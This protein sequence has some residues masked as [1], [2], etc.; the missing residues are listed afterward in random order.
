MGQEPFYSMQHVEAA[1]RY[2]EKHRYEEVISL[3]KNA[4]VTLFSAGHVLGSSIYKFEIAG[5]TL[6]FT[7]D[8]GNAPA[9]LIGPPDYVGKTDYLIIESAYG[10]R[11]HEPANV[12]AKLL[13]EIVMETVNRGGVL[14][15]PSF[16]VER[17]QILL[18]Y[19]N[20]LIEDGRMPKVPIFVDSPLATKVTEVYKKYRAYFK[21]EIQSQIKSGDQI[22]DFPGLNFTRSVDESKAIN[23]I[24]GPKIIIAGNGMS[25]AGRILHHEKRYLSDHKNTILIVGYQVQGSLGRQILDGKNMVR[26]MGE[27][28]E[29]KADVHQITA[30]SAH[31][32]NPQLL[33]FVENK[34]EG[35]PKRIFVVQGEENAAWQ[36][37]QDLND[38]GY[39]AQAPDYRDMFE[40]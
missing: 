24:K 38:R 26:I 3:G 9:P 16:A 17:T 22:F 28:I 40:L 30:F 18:F 6:T 34:I 2:F 5:R 10:D 13:E 25:T 29:V 39:V 14:M 31:A 7:G 1:D 27:T 33:D 21:A 35:R 19:L 36:F 8:V 20:N 32:D 12:G 15:I 23:D 37:A 4:K 11:K